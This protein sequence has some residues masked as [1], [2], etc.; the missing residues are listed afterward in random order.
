MRLPIPDSG[1]PLFYSVEYHPTPDDQVAELFGKRIAF[2]S[3]S[4]ERARLNE[5]FIKH[6][7]GG[8][9]IRGCWKYKHGFKFQPQVVPWISGNH[10]PVIKG[11][12]EGIW[13]RVR[14][15]PFDQTF[16]AGKNRD[17]NLSVKLFNEL[18]GILNWAIEGASLWQREELAIPWKIKHAVAEYR[19]EEDA[20]AE[21][22]E[23][24]IV[25]TGVGVPHSD[26]F[27]AYIG[28]AA[29]AGVRYTMTNK[30]LAKTL[31]ERGW[32]DKSMAAYKV[33][34]RGISLKSSQ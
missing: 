23:E 20:L 30:T 6:A 5:D 13:D 27:K 31:R 7:T 26:V 12:D 25:N 33:F 10:K 28:W 29:H 1:E 19:T 32:K 11:T 21:F 16:V 14:L 3:E 4:R 8:E 22:I 34:W 24:R 15:I 9:E 2:A 18:P 17:A